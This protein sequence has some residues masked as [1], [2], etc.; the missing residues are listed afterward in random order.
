MPTINRQFAKYSFVFLAGAILALVFGCTNDHPQ[1][2]FDTVGPVSE[3]QALIFY[4]IMYA[5]LVVFVL[6]MALLAYFT[7]KYR[8]RDGEEGDPEQVHGNTALEIAWTVAPALL[9]IAVA[10]PSLNSLFDTTVSPEPEALTVKVT[11]NQWWF[12]FDIPELGVVTANELHIPVGEV[13]NIQLDSKDVIHSFWVPKLAGK[14]DMIP[15]NDNTMW[16]QSNEE[17]IFYGQCAEFCGESHALMRFRVVV[18]SK[19]EFDAW[20]ESQLL[21][22][23]K[24]SDPLSQQGHDLFMS[25]EAGCYACHTI[26]GSQKAYGEVGPELTHFASRLHILAG[27]MDNTHENLISWL[28][29]PDE[30]KPGNTMAKNASVYNDPDKAL[31]DS[32]IIALASYLRSLE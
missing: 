5:G 15:N 19:E 1:S 9:L 26:R 8:K 10:V 32:E 29:D 2:T 31:S 30:L 12:R 28:T 11:G 4:I 14:V 24:P 22:A 21:D 20:V 25:S 13:I 17:G 6:V 27:I 3:S 18:D 7:F 16:F 23:V